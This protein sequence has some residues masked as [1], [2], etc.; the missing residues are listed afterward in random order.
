MRT[1][2]TNYRVLGNSNAANFCFTWSLILCT[3][4]PRMNV[5]LDFICMGLVDMPG[6]RQKR[7]SAFNEKFLPKPTALRYVV[8]C[9]TVWATRILLTAV[10]FKLI[11]WTF[12]INVYVDINSRMME[13]RLFCL[14]NVLFCEY[15]ISFCICILEYIYIVQIAKWRTS[16]VSTSD[17]QNTTKHSTRSGICMLKAITGLVRL[18]AIYII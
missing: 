2:L 18:F 3:Y 5:M 11:T 7:Q 17:M 15:R 12:D 1:P 16:P 8:R 10:L 13:N 14:V 6:A 9:S 4:K